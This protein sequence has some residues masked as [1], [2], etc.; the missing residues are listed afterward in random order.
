MPS[1][2]IIFIMFVLVQVSEAYAT[3]I[4]NEELVEKQKSRQ[5]L[6]SKKTYFISITIVGGDCYRTNSK[7]MFSISTYI[8]VHLCYFY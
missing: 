3:F 1:A 6:Y 4:S 7:Y 5:L 2:K 8:L